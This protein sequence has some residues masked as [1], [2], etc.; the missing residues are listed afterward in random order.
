MRRTIV[1]LMTVGLLVGIIFLSHLYT[2]MLYAVLAL[3]TAA[4]KVVS[5]PTSRPGRR[6]P[7][8]L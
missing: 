4:G 3:A 1:L 7:V 5:A 6:A 8:R 2:P